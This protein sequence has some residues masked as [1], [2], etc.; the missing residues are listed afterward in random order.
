MASILLPVVASSLGAN[1]FW[2]GMA[3]LI[4]G[5]LDQRI[6]GARINS[7]QEIGKHSDLQMQT[8]SMGAPIV[9]GYGRCVLQATSSGARSSLSMS[10]RAHS[11]LAARAAVAAALSQRRL[12]ATVFRLQRRF[13]RVRLKAFV[14]SG[15]MAQKSNC[16]VMTLRWIIRCTWETKNNSLI[17]SWSASRVRE[18]SLHIEALPKSS[19]RISI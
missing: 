19:S 1:A 11:V 4:G 15:R 16:R 6:F 12:T 8:A 10:V 5:M 18:T 14:V 17:L 9:S 7:H 3:G 13:A 2:F